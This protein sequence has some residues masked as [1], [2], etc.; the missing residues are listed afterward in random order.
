MVW[1]ESS[2]YKTYNGEAECKL[3]DNVIQEI[4][5]PFVGNDRQVWILKNSNG[6]SKLTRREVKIM[7]GLFCLNDFRFIFE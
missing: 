5:V 2:V 1:L 7:D 3:V 4:L 6:K